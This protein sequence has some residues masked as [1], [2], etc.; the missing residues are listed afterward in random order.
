MKM[1]L[2]GAALCLC[3]ASAALA[4]MSELIGDSVG[5]ETIREGVVMI[6]TSTGGSF[7]RIDVGDRVF[8]AFAD[9]GVVSGHKVTCIPYEVFNAAFVSADQ[10]SFTDYI[11]ASEGYVNVRDGVILIE[12]SFV[13]SLCQITI[14]DEDFA[15]FAAE[16]R[17]GVQDARA[18]CVPIDELEN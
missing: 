7:C 14:S 11:D 13:S 15:R 18:V 16:G 6:E 8:E 5:Y 2:T 9:N 3:G 17:S 4:S 12:E 10:R 1:A